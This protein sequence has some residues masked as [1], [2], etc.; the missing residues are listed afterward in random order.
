MKY[1]ISFLL[2]IA[3]TTIFFI[4][5]AVGR[6]STKYYDGE[7]NE[8]PQEVVSLL[9]KSQFVI[10]DSTED[11]TINKYFYFKNLK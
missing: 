5:Y 9:V 7:D 8:I 11:S 2:L 1:I 3:A 10:M 6:D 4:G